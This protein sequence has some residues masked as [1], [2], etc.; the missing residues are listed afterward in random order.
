[1]S[2]WGTLFNPLQCLT[3]FHAPKPIHDNLESQSQGDSLERRIFTVSNI[4]FVTRTSLCTLPEVLF[5]LVLKTALGGKPYTPISEK[6]KEKPSGL[7]ALM[8]SQG[9]WAVGLSRPRSVPGGISRWSDHFSRPLALQWRKLRPQ[10]PLVH[11]KAAAGRQ[12]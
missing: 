5:L 9:W 11:S 10:E 7:Q 2:F 12:A 4:Y 8:R 3:D 1:M 6:R